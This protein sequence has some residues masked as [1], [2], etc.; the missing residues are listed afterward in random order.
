M[1]N[2]TDEQIREV[3]T[4]VSEHIATWA[5]TRS[6]IMMDHGIEHKLY[7]HSDNPISEFMRLSIDHNPHGNWT[8]DTSTLTP[9]TT[10]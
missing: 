4:R 8:I 6:P 2:Y 7:D 9:E 5:E 1:T 10:K 3:A